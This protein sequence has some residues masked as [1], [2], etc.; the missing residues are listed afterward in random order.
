[1]RRE[2]C[3]KKYMRMRTVIDVESYLKD[4]SQSAICTRNFFIFSKSLITFDYKML[5]R[6]LKRS[7]ILAQNKVKKFSTCPKVF[8]FLIKFLL[9][10]YLFM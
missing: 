6:F 1:M 9:V 3:L 5:P 2:N 8:F 7:N 4:F 10:Y